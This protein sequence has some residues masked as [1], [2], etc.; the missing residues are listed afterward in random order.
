MFGSEHDGERA[1]AALLVHKMLKDE[2]ITYEKLLSVD[3][4][5]Y[6]EPSQTD[7]AKIYEKYSKRLNDWEK[8]FLISISCREE[9]S[10]SEKQFNAL[11]KI[12]I[13]F[14]I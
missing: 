8:E 14:K 11:K 4:S 2:N 1:S 5:D 12:K 3:E 7:A 10:L 9:E 6:D 13:K